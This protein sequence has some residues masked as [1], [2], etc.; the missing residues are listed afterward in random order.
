MKMLDAATD[1]KLDT[2]VARGEGQGQTFVA[3]VI[4][5][6]EILLPVLRQGRCINSITMILARDVTFT[7]CKIQSRN[8][9]STV[10]ILQLDSLG[11]YC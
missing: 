3:R 11:T 6:D 7:R 8:V 4:Q 5:I 9:V 10:P 2:W 1:K